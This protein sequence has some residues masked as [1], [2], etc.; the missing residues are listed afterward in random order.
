MDSDLPLKKKSFLFSSVSLFC[1]R[2]STPQGEAEDGQVEGLVQE[3]VPVEEEGER[4]WERQ[5]VEETVAVPVGQVC[6][7]W[8]EEE[9]GWEAACKGEAWREGRKM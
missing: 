9:P 4:K 6:S 7:R 8:L 5:T 1:H 3:G 2:S